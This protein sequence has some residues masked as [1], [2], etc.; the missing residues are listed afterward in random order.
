MSWLRPAM[1]FLPLV[2][3]LKAKGM[4]AGA[5]LQTN[6]QI[7]LTVVCTERQTKKDR[8]LLVKSLY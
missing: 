2:F 1:D 3:P 7:K 5:S 6:S 8:T 4:G